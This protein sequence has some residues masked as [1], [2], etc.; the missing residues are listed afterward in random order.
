MIS[1]NN[2]NICYTSIKEYYMQWASTKVV[3]CY[4]YVSKYHVYYPGH[5]PKARDS[6]S[7]LHSLIISIYFS[8]VKYTELS[9]LFSDIII[10]K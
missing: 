9:S 10:F 7:L 8:Y 3:S 6:L 1:L 2:F 5:I 4:K